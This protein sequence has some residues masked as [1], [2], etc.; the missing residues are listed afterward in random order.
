MSYV[1]KDMLQSKL[2][3]YNIITHLDITRP[4]LCSSTLFLFAIAAVKQTGLRWTLDT[5]LTGVLQGRSL[6]QCLVSI[7]RLSMLFSEDALR[8]EGCVSMSAVRGDCFVLF[9]PP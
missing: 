8:S 2:S 7:T 5:Y 9:S 3:S 1:P 4:Q 6:A